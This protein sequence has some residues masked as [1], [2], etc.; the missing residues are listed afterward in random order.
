M[1][2]EKLVKIH[3]VVLLACCLLA[4]IL[5]VGSFIWLL[6]ENTEKILP[7]FGAPIYF[8]LIFMVLLMGYFFIPEKITKQLAAPKR[9]IIVSAHFAIIIILLFAMGACM[10]INILVAPSGN[11][12]FLIATMICSVILMIISGLSPI[13]CFPDF[14]QTKTPD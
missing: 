9:Q 7:A 6:R 8:I 5:A 2:T 12:I 11:F 14:N 13:I 4:L 3:K 10:F 1:K